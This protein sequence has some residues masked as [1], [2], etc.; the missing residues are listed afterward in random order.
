MQTMTLWTVSVFSTTVSFA[1][2]MSMP[3][4]A[5]AA[6]PSASRRFLNAGSTQARATISAPREG[7]QESSVSRPR[8]ICSALKMPLSSS[9]SRI[10]RM[11]TS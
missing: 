3:K 4:S 6:L 1:V 7:S 5:T 9:S 11:V 8:R 10:A 2:P